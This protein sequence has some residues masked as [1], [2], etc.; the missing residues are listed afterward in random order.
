[1]YGVLSTT[2]ANTSSIVALVVSA[3]AGVATTNAA[4][5]KIDFIVCL[6]RRKT[7]QSSNCLQIVL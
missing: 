6:L 5:I 1:V 4:E 7:E 2:V 3:I